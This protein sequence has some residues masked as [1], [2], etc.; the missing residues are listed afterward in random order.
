MKVK[1]KQLV[2]ATEAMKE[3]SGA[4]LPAATS[5]RVAMVIRAAQ[6]ALDSFQQAFNE[7]LPQ[8]GQ[9]R[10]DAKGKYDIKDAE[11]F[12]KEV[13]ELQDVEIDLPLEKKLTVDQ[14]GAA[15][16]TPQTLYSLEWLVQL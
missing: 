10:E 7:L 3:L 11:R 16:L 13:L 9:E 12:A 5:Y 1:V 8:V 2:D 15:E 14:L 4:K 6:P